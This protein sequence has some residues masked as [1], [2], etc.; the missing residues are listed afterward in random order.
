MRAWC[1]TESSVGITDNLRMRSDL[2]LL[3]VYSEPGPGLQAS[4]Y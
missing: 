2:T 4:P 1:V 3:T